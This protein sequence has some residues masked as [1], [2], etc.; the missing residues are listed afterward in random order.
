MKYTWNNTKEILPERKENPDQFDKASGA[1][2]RVFVSVQGS[3]TTG[4][5]HHEINKWSITNHSGNWTPE[6]WMYIQE[7]P[8][9]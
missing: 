3:K 8:N 7:L 9:K 4:V 1:S 6:Y 5:Y 2:E